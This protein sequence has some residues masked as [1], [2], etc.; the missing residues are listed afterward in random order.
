MIISIAPVGPSP[1][2]R[3]F[4]V[5]VWAGA[6]TLLWSFFDSPPPPSSDVAGPAFRRDHGLDGNRQ[7]ARPSAAA[8][9]EDAPTVGPAPRRANEASPPV[10]APARRPELPFRFLGKLD[11]G[12]ETSLVLYGRG[13][14]LTVHGPGPLDDD[15]AVDAIE[16]GYLLLRHLSSGTSHILE[17]AARQHPIPVAAGP[18]TAQD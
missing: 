12:G 5:A 11:A 9:L 14:T 18:Q 4:A 13:R 1:W 10:T 15:Y 6:L 3:A 17:L 8:I 2:R 16:D 7:M